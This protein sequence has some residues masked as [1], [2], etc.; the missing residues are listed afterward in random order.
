MSVLLSMMPMS[1]TTAAVNVNVGSTIGSAIG[2]VDSH[3]AR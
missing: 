2:G 1:R 3:N